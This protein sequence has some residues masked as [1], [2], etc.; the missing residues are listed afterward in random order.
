MKAKTTVWTFFLLLTIIL[1]ACVPTTFSPPTEI[2][3]T[4]GDRVEQAVVAVDGNGRSH[5]A[6]VVND[7]I[8]YYRTRY[9]EPLAKFTMEMSG[10]GDNWKQFDPDIGV[11]TNGTAYIVWLEQRGGPE[12]FACWRDVPLVPPVGGYQK[13][14][15]LLNGTNTA[16]IVKVVQRGSIV[17][18]VYDQIN[19]NL[20]ITALF[21]KDFTHSDNH[22][23]VYDYD[24]H[25]ES[26]YVYGMD[27]VIDVNG[28]LH[29]AIL[30]NYT[31]TGD[32][33]FTE[34][35]FYR[36]NVTTDTLGTMTQGM[37]IAEGI[38][39]GEDVEPSISIYTDSASEPRIGI[40][41]IWTPSGIDDIYIDS[42]TVNGCEFVGYHVVG[43]PSSWNTYSAIEDLEIQGSGEEL[44]LS[45]IGDDSQSAAPQVYF[46]EAFDTTIFMEPSDGSASYKFDLDMVLLEPR[47][48]SPATDEVPIVSWG[49][50]DLV[51]ATYYSAGWL[52]PAVKVSEDN[53]LDSLL[54]GDVGSNGSYY[55]GV[56]DACSDTWFTTQAWT[57]QLP[58]I[59]K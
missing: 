34:R 19:Q 28:G 46:T 58:L 42:C 29:V 51:K 22:G 20:R 27:M 21:Y 53:C 44:F 7:R 24:Y 37:T 35:L 55:A 32:P 31:N 39:L 15:V 4:D 33:P 8:V 2:H 43:L 48:E 50:S 57:E 41:S 40:A 38:G 18:A 17:Y 6:G 54:L 11:E 56:W 9:G 3:I 52:T 36:S 12:K 49:E 13:T 23:L 14:C 1:S 16:G 10:S 5:I 45:F 47:P 25:F 26:G 30:D 59:V